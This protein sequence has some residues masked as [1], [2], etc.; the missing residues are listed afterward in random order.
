[1]RSFAPLAVLA[2]LALSSALAIPKRG[3]VSD[4]LSE[5]LSAVGVLTGTNSKTNDGCS[6]WLGN[7]GDYTSEF[8]N[9]SGEDVTL[10]VWGPAASWVNVNVPLITHT[11]NNGSTLNVTYASGISGGWAAIYNDTKLVNGQ[12]SETWG[13]FTFDGTYSTFDVSPEVNMKGHNM[14]I[15]SSECKSSMDTCVFQCTNSDTS[16][17]TEYELVNCATGSQKGAMT[18]TYDGAASGGCLVG[19][20]KYVKVTF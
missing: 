7:D 2:N 9:L 15:E 12:I 19:D 8:E 17:W 5:V 6:A 16:C 11:I 13:E 10:V 14:T 4:V 3:L 20:D 1:M 18:G